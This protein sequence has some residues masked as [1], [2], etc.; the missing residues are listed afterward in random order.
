MLT[1]DG[2]TSWSNSLVGVDVVIHAAARAHV[3]NETE[4][5]PLAVYRKI[6]VEGTLKLAHQAAFAVVRRLIFISSIKVNGENTDSGIAYTPEDVPVPADPYGVSK[7]EP[8]SGCVSFP[9]K[10]G[11]MS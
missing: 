10:P 5:D 2:A 11:W 4:V 6:N 8:K 3:I 1:V 7:M 9:S